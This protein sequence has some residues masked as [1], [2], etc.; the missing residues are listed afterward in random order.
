MEPAQEQV[1]RVFVRRIE[2][3]IALFTAEAL[4]AV[5]QAATNGDVSIATRDGRLLDPIL[6]R[7][8]AG[9]PQIAPQIQGLQSKIDL[10]DWCQ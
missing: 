5:E 1:V 7:V 8:Q 10:G 9:H 3:F 4:Q 6:E 2:L